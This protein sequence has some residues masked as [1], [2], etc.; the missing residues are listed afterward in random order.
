M[1]V[2]LTTA[3]TDGLAAPSALNILSSDFTGILNRLD[4]LGLFTA[5][6][7]NMTQ[8]QNST[9]AT[10]YYYYYECG[11]AKRVGLFYCLRLLCPACLLL[12]YTFV[13]LPL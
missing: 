9:N 10:E 12:C 5:A 4:M 13:R 2:T 3:V 8:G 7:A 11:C 6:F 1:T